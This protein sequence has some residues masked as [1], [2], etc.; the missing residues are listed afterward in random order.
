MADNNEIPFELIRKA[1]IRIEAT[2]EDYLT[3]YLC[4]KVFF[5]YGY[6]EESF[7]KE[8]TQDILYDTVVDMFSNE[9]LPTIFIE[10]LD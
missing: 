4:E 9:R 3:L 5:D 2:V 6:T 8:S 10:I 7:Y 1:I